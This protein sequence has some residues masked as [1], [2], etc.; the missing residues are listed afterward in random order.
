MTARESVLA[1]RVTA[2]KMES[3][4]SPE[5]TPMPNAELGLVGLDYL[6]LKVTPAA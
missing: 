4:S 6:K 1:K 3:I 5:V 2:V